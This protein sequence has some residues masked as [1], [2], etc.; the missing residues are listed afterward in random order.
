MIPIDRT[1]ITLL[2]TSDLHG[3]ILPK[4]YANHEQLEL[5]MAKVYTLVEK[6]RQ[7]VPFTLVIDNGDLL[8]GTPLVY[9]HARVNS[10]PPNPMVLAANAMGYHAA[11]IGN[12]EFNYGMEYFLKAVNESQFPWLSANLL[13]EAGEP[14]FGPPYKV[15]ETEAGVKIGLLGLTTS[16]IPNWEN[17][18]HIQGV[19]FADPVETAKR[20]IPVLREQE[21]VDVVIVSYHGGFERDL[22]TGEATEPLTGENQGYELCNAVEG[23]DVLLTGH[24]HRMISQVLPNGVAVVQPGHAGRALGKVKLELEKHSEEGW[25]IVSKHTELLSVEGVQEHEELVRLSESYETETQQWLDQPMGRIKGDMTVRDAKQVR[26]KDNP[27]IEFINRVQMEISGAE[28]S[29]TALFDNTSPGFPPEVTMRHIVSNYIYPNTLKVVRVSGRDVLEALEQTAEY[30]MVDANGQIEVNPKFVEPKPQHYNYDMWEGIEYRLNVAKPAGQR[31]EFARFQGKDL[32][33]DST[34]DVVMNN[35][36]AGGGGNY[37]M[38]H[39]KPV[40][41][42]IPTDVSEL[43]ANYIFERGTIEADCDGN[44]EVVAE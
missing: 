14:M 10:A 44:W 30:F 22:D 3:N 41:K 39:G 2:E 1:S 42:D 37:L 36:R 7:E 15:F 21:G 5:G 26:L 18:N 12:H 28:I 16:Y 9:H 34:Y 6:E 43:I 4:S 35:Y 24:Q 32:D 11:V 13:N 25:K 33:P 29:N 17:P 40:V 8:Q 27:L 23:V 19:V 38:F 20:W 31:V